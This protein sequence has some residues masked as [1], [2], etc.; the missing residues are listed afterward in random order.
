MTYIPPKQCRI[1]REI[2][3]PI[4]RGSK[5][6]TETCGKRTCAA[7][8]GTRHEGWRR[9]IQHAA[10][11]LRAQRDAKVAA[12]TAER[13]GVLTER[14]REIFTFGRQMFYQD[15]WNAARYAQQRKLRK[16]E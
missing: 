16:V 5:G 13:F 1:C 2:Y 3:T 10:A 7:I 8:H 6:P 4:P 11:V 14:E 9:G 12:Q 15:G